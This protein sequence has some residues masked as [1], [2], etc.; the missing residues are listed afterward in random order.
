MEDCKYRI[1]YT[2]AEYSNIGVKLIRISDLHNPK[3]N[4]DTMPLL[5]L[6]EK[7]IK[8]FSVSIGDVLLARTGAA[9]GTYGIVNSNM[10]CIFGS[11]LI[12]FTFDRKKVLSTFFGYFYESN[13]FKKQQHV[14]RQGSSNVNINAENIKSLNFLLPSILEQQKIISILYDIDKHI[15]QQQ[16]HL[17]NLK[18]LRKSILN[19]KLT[20]EKNVTN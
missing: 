14:I 7:T 19:S 10:N 13:L 12:R 15:T 8:Q 4:Y 6:D 20:K 18:V 1:F 16:S 9:I 2:N 5:E 11:Y 17:T 3:I